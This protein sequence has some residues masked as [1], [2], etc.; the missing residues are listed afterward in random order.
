MGGETMT[1]DDLWTAKVG[2]WR[3]RLHALAILLEFLL[4]WTSLYY[5]AWKL[6]P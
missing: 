6:V 4:I 5:L 2:I 1:G 3:E